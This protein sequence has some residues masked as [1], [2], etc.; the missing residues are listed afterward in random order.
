MTGYDVYRMY[1]SIKLHFNKEHYDHF[2]TANGLRPVK[3]ST[4]EKR[5]DKGYFEAIARKYSKKDI[6][7]LFVSNF[8]YHPACYI[9]E[10]REEHAHNNMILWRK[11]NQ[12]RLYRFKQDMQYIKNFL[13]THTVYDTFDSLFSFYDDIPPIFWMV[14]HGNIKIESFIIMNEILNFFPKFDKNLSG[15]NGK[16]WKSYKHKCLKLTPFLN[17]SSD[18]IER[19][20]EVMKKI[21]LQSETERDIIQQ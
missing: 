18:E 21:F 2:K 15:T 6:L 5:H 3:L 9:S 17:L 13:D 19:M 4:Y 8:M 14:K 16:L 20:K 7:D 1:L 11:Y 12:A 10:L